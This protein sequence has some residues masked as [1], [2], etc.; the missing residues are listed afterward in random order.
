MCL[1]V[2]FLFMIPSYF[3]NHLRVGRKTGMPYTIVVN[4]CP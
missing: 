2:C 3:N 1:E 4:K